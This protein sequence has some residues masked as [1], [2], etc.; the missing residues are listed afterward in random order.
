M[1]VY[2]TPHRTLSDTSNIPLSQLPTSPCLMLRDRRGGVRE[3]KM[4]AQGSSAA[5]SVGSGYLLEYLGKQ[6]QIKC[7][8]TTK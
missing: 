4:A 3:G 2:S 1:V 6:N 8:N 5:E 7:G